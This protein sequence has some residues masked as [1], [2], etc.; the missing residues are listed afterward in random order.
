MKESV[1]QDWEVFETAFKLIIFN[2]IALFW[3]PGLYP[4]AMNNNKKSAPLLSIIV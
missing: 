4:I 2:M 1:T 3:T